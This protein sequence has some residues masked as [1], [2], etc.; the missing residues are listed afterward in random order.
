MRVLAI[1]ALASAAFL[2]A[3]GSDAKAAAFCAYYNGGGTNCGFYT[4]QQCLATIAGVG[5][6]CAEN[7]RYSGARERGRRHRGDY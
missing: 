2:A 7:P 5:G 4:F 3:G 1:L 6:Y